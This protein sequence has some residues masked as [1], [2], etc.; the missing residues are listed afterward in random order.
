MSSGAVDDGGGFRAV[1]ARLEMVDL[2]I[3]TQKNIADCTLLLVEYLQL[4][5]KS[6]SLSEY[7]DY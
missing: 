7:G 3:K 6:L 4:N 5:Y 2:V 1:T